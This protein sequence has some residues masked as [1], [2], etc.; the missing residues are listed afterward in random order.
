M[1]TAEQFTALLEA[2][3]AKNNATLEANIAKKNE[4]MKEDIRSG[5]KEELVGLKEEV[6][7][8]VSDAIVAT[9]ERVSSL[10]EKLK[11]KDKEIATLRKDVS[12]INERTVTLELTA[13]SRNVVL[14]KISENEND[15]QTLA[16]GVS[17]LIRDIADSTFKESD[18][19]EVFRLGKKSSIPRPIMLRLKSSSKR[20]FLLSQKSKFFSKKIGI[21][22]DLPKEII[23]WRKPL[24]EVADCIRKEGKRV[25]F[26]RDKLVVDGVELSTEQIEEEVQKQR[27][28]GRSPG[29]GT[30]LRRTIP[31]LTLPPETPRSQ[32]SL[33]QFYSPVPN[34]SLNRV[35]D[36]VEE[37]S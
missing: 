36:F 18:I 2:N 22:E 1:M 13:R 16:N 5:L 7:Q 10:E 35:F 9:N 21:S 11:E 27:K 23:E 25:S 24:F 34:Q 29:E 6:K 3:N 20:R 33:E 28:R 8:I 4:K 12:R 37:N 17:K 26:R 30:S 14:F 15:N 32:T 31:K 19:E